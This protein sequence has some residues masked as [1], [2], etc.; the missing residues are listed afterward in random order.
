MRAR[1]KWR[2]S[3]NVGVICRRCRC[4]FGIFKIEKLVSL[5]KNTYINDNKYLNATKKI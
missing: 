4:H 5:N 1:E 3:A 2:K